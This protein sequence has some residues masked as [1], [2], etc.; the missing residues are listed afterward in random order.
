MNNHVHFVMTPSTESALANTLGQVSAS[1]AACV[2]ERYGR[3]GHLW[4]GRF[5]SCPLDE[6]HF[7]QTV[8]YVE[9]NPVRAA[10]AQDA[11]AYRWSSAA[12][13]VARS[14]VSRLLDLEA[15]RNRMPP[16]EWKQVLAE[17]QAP[18]EVE[19][20]RIHTRSGR[21]LGGKTFV[22]RVEARLG[23]PVC[24]RPPGRPRKGAA[25]E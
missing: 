7:W 2:N 11:W 8:R 10:M 23:R 25:K 15:W 4:Q 13:H 14:G 24:V 9:C 6:D 17:W 3:S 5:Y 22:K 12:A 20:I 18:A 1:Y 19:N 16:E 21:P